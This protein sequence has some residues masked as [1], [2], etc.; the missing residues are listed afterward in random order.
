MFS[1]RIA[2]VVLILIPAIAS[3]QRG[4][5]GKGGSFGGDKQA[6]YDKM[7]G[8]S[9]ALQLANRDLEDISP[10]KL[11][12][13]KRKDLR[14]ADDKV[15]QIKELEGKL[16]DKNEPSFKAL[17][18]LRKEMKPSATPSDDDRTRMMSARSAVMAAVADIRSNYGASVKEAMALLD[19]GQQK[20]ANEMLQKQTADAEEMLREKLNGRRGG[21]DTDGA[22]AGRKGRPPV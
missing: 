14:L 17:D 11:L 13:D 16:K 12:I 15:K 4:G 22:A 19:E 20:T 2:G 7:G 18:S 6:N 10:I 3:A 5:G 9:S 21:G 1:T 8:T